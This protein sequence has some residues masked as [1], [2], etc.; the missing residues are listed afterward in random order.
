LAA[1]ATATAAA[2]AAGYSQ[3]C[4]AMFADNPA[5]AS[6]RAG[7]AR[8]AAA[9]T[10]VLA[11][12]GAVARRVQ[13]KLH[14]ASAP[15][16]VAREAQKLYGRREDREI[17]LLSDLDRSRPRWW[18]A[19]LDAVGSPVDVRPADAYARR[20]VVGYARGAAAYVVFNDLVGGDEPVR[21][22]GCL[23]LFDVWFG[24]QPAVVANLKHAFT[25]ASPPSAAYV[26]GVQRA[27][28]ALENAR[29]KATPA[30][31][32]NRET[33]Q[34]IGRDPSVAVVYHDD[35]LPG[36]GIGPIDVVRIGA[37]AH[38]YAILYLGAKKPI[39]LGSGPYCVVGDERCGAYYAW[40]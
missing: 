40:P 30:G 1:T 28:L 16:I 24:L 18:S 37:T 12:N 21:R 11:T 20:A 35:G 22:D 33:I 7:M 25:N 38:T 39:T 13:Q 36:D 23:A 29:A 2:S 5:G 9:N 6:Y 8:Q 34:R 10:A 26:A 32:I 4:K 17:A 27:W 3:F 19:T 15:V 31:A 14:L